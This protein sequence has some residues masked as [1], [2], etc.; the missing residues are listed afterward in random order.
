MAGENPPDESGGGAASPHA[1][2]IPAITVQ[3]N[4]VTT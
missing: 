2:E 3:V 1:A 4:K